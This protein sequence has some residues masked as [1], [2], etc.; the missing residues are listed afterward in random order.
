M[1]SLGHLW[2]P[3]FILHASYW[4]SNID[5][6]I[7]SLKITRKQIKN[8]EL[9]SLMF[10]V[11]ENILLC[12]TD[13]LENEEQA[14]LAFTL[15]QMSIDNLIVRTANDKTRFINI[16]L[17]GVKLFTPS[18]F[19]LHSVLFKPIIGMIPI[20]TVIATI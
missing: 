17:S 2:A 18:A 16:L 10:D 14:N 5:R 7:P 1:F 6:I 12:R 9:D 4:P 15:L 3:L 8:L 11:F 13:L 20:E 19:V